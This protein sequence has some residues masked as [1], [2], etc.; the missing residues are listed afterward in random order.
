MIKKANCPV[1]ESDQLYLIDNVSEAVQCRNCGSV[2]NKQTYKYTRELETYCEGGNLDECVWELKRE[3]GM[4]ED[5][6]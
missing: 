3:F 1:C 6:S 4:V 5:E 2:F